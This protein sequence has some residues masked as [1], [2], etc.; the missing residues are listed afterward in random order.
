MNYI[1][2]T[3]S[4]IR[5][6]T[7]AAFAVMGACVVLS[8]I[9]ATSYWTPRVEKLVQHVVTSYDDVMPEIT[10][11]NGKASIRKQQPYFVDGLDDESVTVVIDT[12]DTKL[13]DALAYLK[14]TDFGLVLTQNALILKS[15]DGIRMFSLK[16]V[17]DMVL[18]SA[19]I[20]E[21]AAQYLPTLF[22]VAAVLTAVYFLLVKL[23]QAILL[24]LV[25]LLWARHWSVSLTY[26]ESF[27]I[28]AFAMVPPVALDLFQRFTGTQIPAS[29]F[30]YFGFYVALLILAGRAVVLSS[31][32]E[33]ETSGA[34]R[35]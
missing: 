2:I 17:P 27:K 19:S 21:L 28:A 1:G 23:F 29:F 8:A 12:R 3:L 26:G 20:Q 6:P 31:L 18:N 15:N 10:I 14:Q 24:A 13:P 7:V 11:R 34:I 25:P 35:T 4:I 16:D 5:T 9:G 22:R 33:A 30:V 32:P